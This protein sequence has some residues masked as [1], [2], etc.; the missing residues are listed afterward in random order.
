MDVANSVPGHL[1]LRKLGNFRDLG[2]TV[3]SRVPWVVA[4]EGISDTGN[5]L[6]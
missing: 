4:Q 6:F 5:H 2:E 1:F 3:D